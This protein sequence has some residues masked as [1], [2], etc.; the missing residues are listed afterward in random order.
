ML[1]WFLRMDCM[2]RSLLC[3]SRSSWPDDGCLCRWSGF[4]ALIDSTSVGTLLIPIWL[5]L[6]PGRVR[7]SRVLVYLSTV[8]AFYLVV[9][10]F[11]V[12]GAST[13][14]EEIETALAQQWVTWVQ[15]VVGVLLFAWSWRLDPKRRPSGSGRLLRWRDRVTGENGSAR[16]LMLL[17]VVAA[18]IEVATMLPY[19]AAIGIITAAGLT[20]LASGVV[21]AAFCLVMVL[22]AAVLVIVRLAATGAITPVLARIDNWFTKHG[23]NTTS[24]IVGIVGV[25]LALDALS[26]LFCGPGGVCVVEW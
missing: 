6:A 24:W 3:G 19:L 9:G 26:R 2:A 21:V 5:L 17:A 12:L 13:L 8:A 15:L 25:L 16:G 10:V 11:S 14:R 4:L 7:V 23:Q 22:P 18:G 1:A 20:W